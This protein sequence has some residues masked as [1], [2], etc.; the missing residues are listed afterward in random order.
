LPLR[1]WKT[2]ILY[3]LSNRFHLTVAVAHYPIGNSKRNS[4]EHRLFSEICKGGAS[5]AM[6]SHEKILKFIRTTNIFSGLGATAYFDRTPYTTGITPAAEDGRQ[7]CLLA[8]EALP[9]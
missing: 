4:A 1:A 5:E 2:E 3:Q 9:K 8:H 7:F 6:T